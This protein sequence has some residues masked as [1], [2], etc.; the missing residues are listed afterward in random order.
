MPSFSITRMLPVF[1]ESALA[2][3]L[4]SQA[5]VSKATPITA[6]DASSTSPCPHR[7]R[8]TE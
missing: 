4:C 5:C 1:R 2:H 3:T 7:G 6:L 8:A